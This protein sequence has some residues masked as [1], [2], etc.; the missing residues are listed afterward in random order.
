MK[1]VQKHNYEKSKGDIEAEV[2][3]IINDSI[4]KIDPNIMKV[5]DLVNKLNQTQNQQLEIINS[6]LGSIR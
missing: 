4:K 1:T 2:K 3:E 5:I 6:S